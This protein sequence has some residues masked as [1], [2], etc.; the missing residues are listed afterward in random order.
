MAP[1]ETSA[2]QPSSSPPEEPGTDH[3]DEE[4]PRAEVW[5]VLVEL[6]SVSRNE[7]VSL[8]VLRQ[9][10]QSQISTE[11]IIAVLKELEDDGYVMYRDE[12][13]KCIL[14]KVTRP[15]GFY[16]TELANGLY[17]MTRAR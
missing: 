11:E 4:A 9:R 15:A 7:M 17:I 16:K 8:H 14:R 1:I 13:G 5:R 6:F 3:V 12:E 10:I 2:A